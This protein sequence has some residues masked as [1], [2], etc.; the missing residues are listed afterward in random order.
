MV[1]GRQER[2]H[3]E[4]VGMVELLRQNRKMIW[5]AGGRGFDKREWMSMELAE[6]PPSALLITGAARG[7]DLM[8]EDLWR[9]SQRP[10]IGI[11]AAWDAQ[12]KAAGVIRNQVIAYL[13]PDELVVFPG[14]RGTRDAVERA[15]KH[16]IPVRYVNG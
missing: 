10:Y 4:G 14:G 6:L 11:P 9:R 16:N 3:K 15:D 13:E 5:V 2:F 7:A 8:A 1:Q 12:G